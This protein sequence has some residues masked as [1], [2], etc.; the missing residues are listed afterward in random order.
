[1][2]LAFDLG[3]DERERMANAVDKHSVT[4]SVTISV[5]N[6][7]TISVTSSVTNSMTGLV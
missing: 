5:T 6:S 2:S 7:V 4:D 3:L 1:M